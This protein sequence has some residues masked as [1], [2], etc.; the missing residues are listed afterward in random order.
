MCL[1]REPW[2][3]EGDGPSLCFAGRGD[4]HCLVSAKLALAGDVVGLG[5]PSNFVTHPVFL[6]LK[7]SCVFLVLPSSE[8]RMGGPVGPGG[9]PRP[10][11]LALPAAEGIKRTAQNLIHQSGSGVGGRKTRKRRKVRLRAN[12]IFV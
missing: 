10:M 9:L 3:G 5:A 8:M 7:L 1:K 2:A 4:L 11:L 6:A 12:D